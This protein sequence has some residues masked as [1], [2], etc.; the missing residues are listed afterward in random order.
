MKRLLLLLFVVVNIQLFAQ[1]NAVINDP[2]AE[3]RTLKE[4]FSTISVT[5]GIELYLSQG[6]DESIAVSASDPKYMERYKTEVDNG[7]LRIYYDN[8]GINWTGNEKRRLRAYV[9]FKALEKLNASGGASVNM[10]SVLTADKM[11]CTF[12]SGSR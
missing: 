8:K 4:S 7:V 1:D 6:N 12:T 10:K 5:D 2:N 3:K 9:S 11:E